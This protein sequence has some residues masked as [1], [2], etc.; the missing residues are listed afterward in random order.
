M[1][2]TTAIL[3]A[4]NRAK[5]GDEN[6]YTYLL[7]TFWPDVYRFLLSKT[8]E[9]NEA[10]DLTIRSFSR[11]FDRLDSFNPNYKFKNWLL[12]IANNLFID[13]LRKRK[14]ETISIYKNDEEAYDVLDEEPTPIDQLI[15]EQNLAQL[16]SYIKQLKPHYQEIIMLRFFQ[17]MQYKEMAET[18]QEPLSTI[19]VKL[20]RAK[21]LLT[22]IIERN[23]N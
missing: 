17:E 18:L 23:S 9:E 4:I 7:N 21:K 20:L 13:E 1:K 15:N 6:A 8:T 19:K 16:L 2:E 3:S 12:A 22:E 11:A 5:N 14:T 10:E